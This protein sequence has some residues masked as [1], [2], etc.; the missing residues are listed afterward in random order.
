MA[1][2]DY[3]SE[4]VIILSARSESYMAVNKSSCY[5]AEMEAYENKIC[6]KELFQRIWN[7]WILD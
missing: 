3:S 7:A 5:R 1:S 6:E 2:A 4:I